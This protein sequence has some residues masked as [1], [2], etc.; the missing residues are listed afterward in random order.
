[1]STDTIQYDG[2]SFPLGAT[3]SRGGANF[4]VFTKHSSGV[5]LL[6]FDR[7]DDPQPSRVFD[8]DPRRNRTYQ[9]WHIFVPGVTAGQLYGY[10]VSGPFDPAR[11]CVLLRT[12][13]SSIHTKRVLRGAYYAAGMRR[14]DPGTTRVR[15]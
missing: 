6:L 7:V 9:Y 15:R 8:L 4:S 10:R 1:M 2:K 11:G 5:Q 12:R 3:L 13:C 14:D